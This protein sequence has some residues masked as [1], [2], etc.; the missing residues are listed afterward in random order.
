MN[1]THYIETR[2]KNHKMMSDKLYTDT[3]AFV[4]KPIFATELL[5]RYSPQAAAENLNG[6][7]D[8]MVA[9]ANAIDM[10]YNAEIKKAV[11]DARKNTLPDAVRNREVPADYQL[12]ISNALTLLNMSGDKITDDEAF[13]ILKPFFNDW[14]QMR[15]F[16]RAMAHSL[17]SAETRFTSPGDAAY[18]V[19]EKF[20]RTFGGILGLAD[21]HAELFDEAE[22]LA[23]HI[24]TNQRT[25]AQEC[26][27][28]DYCVRGAVQSETYDSLCTQDRLLVLA[29]EIDAL[30]DKQLVSLAERADLL[31]SKSA[32]PFQNNAKTS[33]PY[34]TDPDSDTDFIWE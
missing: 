17:A 3:R 8:K 20:P 29:K 7:I 12:Q 6:T 22:I 18:A 30:E 24:F 2:I 33:V 25:Y 28:G 5:R 16:E 21:M 34:N 26:Y 4:E 27:I 9:Q 10:L 32:D 19:R 14:E 11:K 13:D 1:I 31:F 15:I 23:E